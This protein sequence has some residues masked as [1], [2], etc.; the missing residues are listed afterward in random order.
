MLAC[1]STLCYQMEKLYVMLDS[2]SLH[3]QK[4]VRWGSG[5]SAH[6]PYFYYI[7]LFVQASAYVSWEFA[8]TLWLWEKNTHL[9]CKWL[10]RIGMHNPTVDT[11]STIAPF[12]HSRNS[13]E[14]NP[15]I[16][17]NSTHNCPFCWEEE[18]SRI[19]NPC[20]LIRCFHWFDQIQGRNIT[21]TL[22][23]S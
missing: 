1:V 13:G 8:A 4:S 21:E 10:C 2:C 19:M 3:K 11:F 7:I 15:P 22:V 6:G 9:V 16:T 23:T 12:W 17:L 18:M 5:P 20:W 14:K